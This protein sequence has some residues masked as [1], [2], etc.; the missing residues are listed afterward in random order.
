MYRKLLALALVGLG[1]FL[2]PE[3]ASAAEGERVRAAEGD[4][5]AFDDSLWGGATEVLEFRREDCQPP[6]SPTEDGDPNAVGL[7]FSGCAAVVAA[8]DDVA[9]V[10]RELNADGGPVDLA[11][12]S[13]FEAWVRSDAELEICLQTEGL[14][15]PTARCVTHG[16]E[17]NGAR[18]RWEMPSTDPLVFERVS[19][20]T[21]ATREGGE[22]HLEVAELAFSTDVAGSLA[23]VPHDAAPAVGCRMGGTPSTALFGLG[24]LML[25]R[26]RVQA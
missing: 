8:A 11:R 16:A 18:V 14:Y 21:F 23:G 12:Y 15:E 2:A 19:L 17:P 7:R 1:G 6:A 3:V 20:V 22:F 25:A 26:K 13:S 24:F 5:V 10:A 4:W 9:G